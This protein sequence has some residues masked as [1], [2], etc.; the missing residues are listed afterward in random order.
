MGITFYFNFEVNFI[1]WLQTLANSFTITLASLLSSLGDE[2]IIV[3]LIAYFYWCYDKKIGKYIAI[4]TL[5]VL[6]IGPFIK[7]IF[8]RR[9]PYMDHETIK[10]LKPVNKEKDIYD[11]AYQ[12]Y[13][14]PSMHAANTLATYGSIAN[15]FK[16]K[17]LTIITIIILL[18]IGLSRSFVG[19]HYP[20]DV[21]I[22]WIISL[23]VIIIMTNIQKKKNSLYI[24]FILLLITLPGWFFCTSNDFYS[25]YGLIIGIFT[26]FHIE[27]KYINFKNKQSLLTNIIRLLGGLIIFL[28]INSLLKLPF[29]ETFLES[30]TFLS[31]LIRTL[32]YAISSFIIIGIYPF[33]FKYIKI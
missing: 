14:L 30:A 25:S 9:R 7:N 28:L 26:G 17:W 10:C 24:M 8:T 23:I 31:Y 27:E 5:S 6:I 11:I 18:L 13:S 4:N 1:I 21:I 33:T 19:V 22:G 15:Y 20:T 16:K 29:N 2:L 32:R 12:G 3:S